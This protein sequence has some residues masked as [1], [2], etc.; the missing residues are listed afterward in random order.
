MH[1]G[2]AGSQLIAFEENG[3][4]AFYDELERFNAELI[5]FI[6]SGV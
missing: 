5:R 1:K 2:I 3:H 6:K 4:G